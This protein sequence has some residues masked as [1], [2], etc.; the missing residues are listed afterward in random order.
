M[1]FIFI[2]FLF[3]LIPSSFFAQESKIDS[4][5]VKLAYSSDNQKIDLLKEICEF[6][7][8]NALEKGFVYADSLYILSEKLNNKSAMTRA[9]SYR[10]VFNP[11]PEKGIEDLK[12][13]V[14]LDS[15]LEFPDDLCRDKLNLASLYHLTNQTD[16]A[17]KIL[18]E[19]I[20]YSEK[21]ELYDLY[22]K[23]TYNLTNFY[24]QNAN[25]DLGLEFCKNSLK[26]FDKT[27][28]YN[29]QTRIYALMSKIYSHLKNHPKSL[30]YALLGKEMINEHD[31]IGL[32]IK[33][34]V[35]ESLSEANFNLKNEE[36][37]FKYYVKAIETSKKTFFYNGLINPL[38]II[39]SHIS[40]SETKNKLLLERVYQDA[41]EIKG[42]S[43]QINDQQSYYS[44]QMILANL[45]YGSNKLK[46]SQ[47]LAQQIIDSSKSKTQK[48]DIETIKQ[49]YYLLEKINVKNKDY[50]NAYINS[51]KRYTI[52][53]SLYD[54]K[55]HNQLS[56]LDVKYQTEKKEKQLAQQK[57]ATQEQELLAQK[58]NIRNWLLV[59][60]LL[61]VLVSTFFIW[62]RYK[63]EAKA[64][65]IIS[66]QKTQI[67]KLQKEFHHRLKNDFRS[68][69]SY[70]GLV[71]RQFTD[72][73]IKER[74][75][76]LKNRVTSMFKVHEI[77]LQED[78]ITQVK[79]HPYL[80]ELS[81][82]VEDKYSN[83]NIKVTCNVDATETIVADKAIPFGIVLNEFVT[84]SYKYAFDENGGE[85]NID[86]KSD[87]DNHYLT[88]KDNGKGLPDDFNIENLRSLG[89]SIIPMFADLHDGSYQLD[90]SNGVSLTLT[91]PKKVA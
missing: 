39:S 61:A 35:Y 73:N 91:L 88:L 76:E 1:R 6:Y 59:I 11:V 2:L 80:L 41:K 33:T 13:A 17:K 25:Y 50:K 53:D 85:I 55:Y 30:E 27:K 26:H 42:I 70:I 45:E 74:L 32:I 81:Q 7:K 9:L 31:G 5:I 22:L 51:E 75:N 36:E 46:E 86:F 47:N 18:K 44:I 90:G 14:H 37:G 58:A 78:D 57:I 87:N 43:N 83:E 40:I 69:N 29:T 38:W 10:G 24:L 65:H 71:Q 8:V 79:A 19:V 68:I 62:R 82:N 89:M 67:E 15:I 21:K 34:L 84:N 28:D 4:L 56:S 20:N 63:T 48:V 54:N 12:R 23:A 3:F 16:K 49:A 77:L 64:K 60:G 66:E 52:R 72:T